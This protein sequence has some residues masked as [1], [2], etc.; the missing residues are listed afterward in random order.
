MNKE[1]PEPNSQGPLSQAQIQN[2]PSEIRNLKQWVVWRKEERNGKFTKVPIRPADGRNADV[3][4]PDY[5]TDFAT[6]L[7]ACSQWKAEG[8]GFVFTKGD[9]Y[10][11]IDFDN[12]RDPKTGQPL[13]WAKDLL[14]RFKSYTENSVSGTGYHV[15][16]KARLPSFQS[17]FR[18]PVLDSEVQGQVEIYTHFR[19]FTVTGDC[20]SQRRILPQQ[21]AV[22]ELLSTLGIVLPQ[23]QP[24]ASE[25]QSNCH[26]ERSDDEIIDRVNESPDSEK[27]TELYH[28]NW[29]K[30]HY[31][32][33]S[34]AD[35]ALCSILAKV[36]RDP[37]AIDRIVSNSELGER[38]KWRDG[39]NYRKR[40]IEKA[41]SGY[42]QAFDSSE[43]KLTSQTKS[44]Q[45]D[46]YYDSGRKE[47]LVENKGKRWL[48]HQETSFKRILRSLGISTAFM[49]GSRLSQADQVILT[50][51]NTRDV[52]F[53]GP[54]A[55][56]KAGFY[57]ENG[58]RLLVTHSPVI[59]E[60]CP[61]EWPTLRAVFQGLLS[62]HQIQLDTFFAWLKIAYE[63]VRSGQHRPGQAL[64]FAGP[65]NCGKSL[66][67]NL[68]TKILGGR[69]A[70]AFQFLSGKT[71]FNGEL[72]GAEHL[73]LEDEHS[74]TDIRSRH[75]LGAM[76]KNLAVNETQMC[77]RKNRTP[78]N[79]LPLWRLTIS[80]NDEPE[81][82]LVL[83]P[84]NADISDKL[85]ILKCEQFEMPMPTNTPEERHAF[86]GKL[87]EEIPAFLAFLEDWEIPAEQ[88]CRRF[89]IKTYQHPDIVSELD[90]LAPEV[91]LLALMDEGL[92]QLERLHK[93]GPPV[94]PTPT[95]A[96]PLTSSLDINLTG[97]DTGQGATSGAE[98][99]GTAAKLETFV[100]DVDFPNCRQIRKLLSWAYALGT[101][102][103]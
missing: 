13:P 86:W 66:V 11:G 31:P 94:T 51:Q 83:P 54:L 24:E 17:G 47:Y 2:I 69:S 33:Q 25:L 48:N 15:F 93:L 97:V 36:T 12:A 8:I 67:Q 62:N 27:F 84:L 96:Q 91:R 85:I 58:I 46:A 21:E 34:E 1:Q 102:L 38:G 89:G 10:V 28:G 19:F 37:E 77:H 29:E 63:A 49:E 100:T 103:G 45:I 75:T 98:W 60:P 80:L 64:A 23:N 88:Q 74:S 32:S 70:K 4:N 57:E 87:V 55:G 53:A 44:P 72:F 81:A 52:M 95:S 73:M 92:W 20:V 7:A 22:D 71:T 68:I 39:P 41:L 101:Y 5:S 82:L 18:R 14:G 59:I 50:I 79:L 40:T 16:V 9:P 35:L 76:I 30:L 43:R 65:V 90:Q 6:A 26:E 61:G 78:V 56:R 42:D 3:T 99:I